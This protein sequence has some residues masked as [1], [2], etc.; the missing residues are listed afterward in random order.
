MNK[1]NINFNHTS[2]QLIWSWYDSQRAVFMLPKHLFSAITTVWQIVNIIY[3]YY[4][5][6]I[7]T[8]LIINRNG[9]IRCVNLCIL[10]SLYRYWTDSLLRN[11]ITSSVKCNKM[12]PTIW[13]IFRVFESVTTR[14][15]EACIQHCTRWSISHG[16]GNYGA[17]KDASRK[18]L[19]SAEFAWMRFFKCDGVSKSCFKGFYLDAFCP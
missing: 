19:I 12:Q 10:I 2:V 6:F 13:I 1:K 18:S 7:G 8:W 15:I 3:F 14:N 5:F 17:C 11:Q 9:T 16:D 4:Y